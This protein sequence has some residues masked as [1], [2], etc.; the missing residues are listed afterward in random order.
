LLTKRAVYC[1]FF[2]EELV[3][4]AVQTVTFKAVVPAGPDIYEVKFDNGAQGWKVW[5]SPEC[6][7]DSAKFRP[8]Q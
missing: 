3:V 7:V 2:I 5:L 6:K 4:T 1:G 8:A